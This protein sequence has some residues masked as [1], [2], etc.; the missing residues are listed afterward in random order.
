MI[1]NIIF[2]F[3]LLALIL[4]SRSADAEQ[5]IVAVQGMRIKPYEEALRGFQS[6]CNAA[7]QEIVISEQEESEIVKKIQ[8]IKPDL[9]LAVGIEALSKVK[10]IKEIPIVYLMVLNPPNPISKQDNI[11][12]VNMNIPPEKQL[13][14]FQQV[15][16]KV[17]RIGL[18]YDPSKTGYLVEKALYSSEKLG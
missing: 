14:L 5:K 4:P 7:I 15:L 2:I 6:V 11:T 3:L 13:G 16:F 8:R 17:K 10:K 1:K 12:G 9:I 18:L